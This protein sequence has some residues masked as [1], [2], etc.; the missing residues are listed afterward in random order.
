MFTHFLLGIR[1]LCINNVKP[2][3]GYR[4]L[5]LCLLQLRFNDLGVGFIELVEFVAVVLLEHTLDTDT[6]IAM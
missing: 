6:D 3:P 1:D 4:E 2:L 5:L